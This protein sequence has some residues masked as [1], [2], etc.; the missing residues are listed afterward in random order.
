MGAALLP[1]WE[2]LLHEDKADG[3]NAEH[4]RDGAPPPNFIP[5][6]PPALSNGAVE[7]D[8]EKNN[9]SPPPAP[10]A[11]SPYGPPIAPYGPPF[12]AA[13]IAAPAPIVPSPTIPSLPRM[14]IPIGAL[15]SRFPM[16]PVPM[17]DWRDL[18]ALGAKAHAV[19]DQAVNSGY[20]QTAE[21]IHQLYEMDG[22]TF[23]TYVKNAGDLPWLY[24]GRS[25]GKLDPEENVRRRSAARYPS[26][27]YGDAVLDRS[28]DSY[29]AI[30][31]REQDVYNYARWCGNAGNKINPIS[32]LNP[33]GLYYRTKSMQEFGPVRPGEYP[34]PNP[35]GPQPR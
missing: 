17:P 31:G 28:S 5:P 24:V 13:P 15:G 25:S 12:G 4:W 22:K 8:S 35:Q 21:I 20:M 33:W 9:G 30:R 3:E 19:I 11:P 1:Y 26:E 34:C 2:W 7:S 23:Q 27:E 16:P 18:E 29:G 14:Q 32:P 6:Q 10:T